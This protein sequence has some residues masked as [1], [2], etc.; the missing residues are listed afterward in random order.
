METKKLLLTAFVAMMTCGASAQTAVAHFDMSLN[1]GK[2]TESVANKSYTVSSKLPAC[3]VAGQDGEALRFDGYS[4]YVL[5]GLPVS[6]FSTSLLTVSLTLAPES[7]PMMQTAPN[8]NTFATVCGN[9]DE[10]AKKGFAIELSSQGDLRA[11]L[12]VNYSGGYQVSLNGNQKL[13]RGK[14]S[15]I[16]M[17]YD[18]EGNAAVLY[19][20]GTEIAR[21]NTNRCD[22]LH[23]TG[24]FYIGKDA[25]DV[26]EGEFLLNTFC[27][28]IDDIAVYNS[29][30]TPSVVTPEL[31]DL[32][33]PASR[34][35]GSLWRPAFHCMP[36]GSWTNE[37]HGMIY[38]NGRYH[39]FSQKNPNGPY[40]YRLH[41]GHYTSE[42]L[43]DWKEEPLA[44]CPSEDF[45]K[46]GCWSGCVFEDGDKTYIVYT[47]IGEGP[48]RIAQACA[49]DATLM[50]WKDKKIIINGQIGLD[51]DF[52]DPYFFTAN[53]KKYLIVGG[54]K[55]GV[56]CCTLHKWNGTSW[57]N[58]GTLFFKSS[59]AGAQ[60]TFWE[61]PN[62]TPMGNGKWLFTVTPQGLGTGVRTLYWIGT[63]GSNGTFTPDNAAA[64]PLE[65]GGIGKDGYG[66]LS[67]TIYQYNGKTLLLG[68][69]PDKLATDENYKMG[70]AHNMSLVREISLDAS[71]QLVQKPYSGL[72]AMRTETTATVEKSIMGSESLSPVSG[73]QIEL[74]G[75]FTVSTAGICG[76]RFMKNGSKQA[77]LQYNAATGGLSLNTTSLARIAN[78][79]GTWTASLPTKVP[80]GSKLKLHVF[81]DGSIADIFVN[82]RWAF[83]TRIFSTDA[84]QVKAEVM[85]S[86]NMPVNVQAWKL[87]AGQT[88][89]I[90][91][92]KREAVTT[93]QNIY[94]LQGRRLNA[95]QQRG[96]YIIGGRKYV[97]K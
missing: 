95:A 41:W 71:G 34:Y 45:D 62:V 35:E 74:L 73:T 5:A 7:Y 72:T 56:G 28:A 75:E 55:D 60:G 50:E 76:F 24:T 10:T 80:S 54:K 17:T 43:I 82:D 67:P 1:N 23:N 25:T 6:T 57:T 8:V 61:M 89:G 51:E 84:A 91:T 36:S 9:L 83:S 68:I 86:I 19:L 4:N 2:I 27:G 93:N 11:R 48:A 33:Y 90:E 18:K 97:R 88:T 42:N 69:V 13:P 16:T 52:R 29:V 92:V 77:T 58:D 44:I 21:R 59:S 31:A 79:N 49:T 96:I 37:C 64:Q 70:W 94:D 3:S 30:V 47:A 26:K 66:L 81:L 53:G 38:S 63:I 46:N 39:V 20:N 12:Y 87:D 22:L 85:T 32:A 78:D 65:M 14:W 40:M 15:N